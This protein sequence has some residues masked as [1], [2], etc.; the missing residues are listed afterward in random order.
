MKEKIKDSYL[1]SQGKRY[2]FLM[3]LIK[4]YVRERKNKKMNILII[5]P[6]YDAKLILESYKNL[7]VVC[8]GI[9]HFHFNFAKMVIYDLN[10]LNNKST[11]PQLDKFDLVICCE[12]IEHLTVNLTE[13][14]NFFKNYMKSSS[15]LI[16]QTPNALA[17]GRR[18]QILLGKNYYL[19]AEDLKRA[20]THLREYTFSELRDRANECGLIIIK[21][22]GKN[23]FKSK[24]TIRKLLNSTTNLLP[25]T[26]RQGFTVVYSLK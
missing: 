19:L 16:I 7:D 12:V 3:D 17:F 20:A 5:G 26:F 2:I 1:E 4:K 14:Y 6:A 11:W 24:N 18:I 13:I 8:L 21:Y 22:Y 25:R 23:Y 10:N 9:D 15:N